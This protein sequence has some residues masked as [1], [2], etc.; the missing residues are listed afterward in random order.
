M[1]N[2]AGVRIIGD[3]AEQ[4]KLTVKASQE[5]SNEASAGIGLPYGENYTCGDIWIENVMLT[6][7]GGKN[8]TGNAGG[9]AIGTNGLY[10]ALCGNITIKDAKIEAYPGPG[11]AAIGFGMVYGSGSHKIGNITIENTEIEAKLT[12]WSDGFGD[13]W[14]AII[15][16]GTASEGNYT[17]GDIRITTSNAGVSHQDYFKDC[18]YGTVMVGVTESTLSYTINNGSGLAIYWNGVKQSGN[19]AK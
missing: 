19:I 3:G 6:V 18:T 13:A 1:E 9:A 10:G 7:A 2:R 5:E 16:L 8:K 17:V 15:G 4:S 14:P 12:K 11:A